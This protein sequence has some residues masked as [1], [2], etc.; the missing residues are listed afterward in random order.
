MGRV[1]FRDE[2]AR[3][4]HER[5]VRVGVICFDLRENRVEQIRVMNSCVENVRRWSANFARDQCQTSFRVNWSLVF[6]EHD[7]C[8]SALIEPRVHP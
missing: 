4:E 3:I 6:S 7:Q 2:T 1:C 8:W 5:I